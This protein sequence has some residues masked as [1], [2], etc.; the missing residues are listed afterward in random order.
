[1]AVDGR[2][3]GER[4]GPPGNTASASASIPSAASRAC[5]ASRSMR[6]R[7]TRRSS[8]AGLSRPCAMRSASSSP[9]CCDQ[10]L[11]QPVRQV[12]AHRRPA[13]RRCALRAARAAGLHRPV[14]AS[15][16]ADRPSTRSSAAAIS[17]VRRCRA[18]RGLERALAA[19]HG[20]HRF[21]DE[22]ALAL[23]RGCDA[24]GSRRDSSWS[25]GASKRRI[26]ESAPA[27]CASSARVDPHGCAIRVATCSKRVPSFSTHHDAHRQVAAL[28]GEPDLRHLARALVACA[29][30]LSVSNSPAGVPSCSRPFGL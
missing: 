29:I 2:L 27:A 3:A 22:G 18:G 5:A 4:A 16:R 20:E 23:A 26:L 17:A 15:A 6:A 24:R 11:P 25:A 12:G 21:G 28:G 7:L 14:P 10:A 30:T 1:M 19:Q 13:A 8:G 9:C